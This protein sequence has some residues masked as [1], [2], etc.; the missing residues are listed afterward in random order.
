MNIDRQLHLRG[1][2]DYLHSTTLF[3]DIL[4][5]RGN[6]VRQIDFI[7]NRKTGQQV[8]YCFE[9]VGS[10]VAPVAV[11]RDE[12]ATIY[13]VARDEPIDQSMSYDEPGLVARCEFA[14]DGNVRIPA[15]LGA[16][17]VMEALVAAFKA[18]LQRTVATH[19]PQVVF[20][21]IRLSKIPVLPLTIRYRRRI[22]E[23]YQG[24]ILADG[25]GIGQIFFGEWK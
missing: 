11:W 3:D 18:L 21:R 13:V 16:F 8:S 12:E 7:F 2:R 1:N 20:A 19:N 24:D 25:A 10:D 17:T 9:P 6:T 23:F 14:A 22:G 15:D 4:S 5:L